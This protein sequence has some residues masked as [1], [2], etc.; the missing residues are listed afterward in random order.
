[1]AEFDQ[2]TNININNMICKRI[3]QEKSRFNLV[4]CELH[5]TPIHGK[6][7]TSY[8]NIES[9]YL[10]IEMFSGLSGISLYE[11]ENYR[12]YDTDNEDNDSVSEN[13]INENIVSHIS[14]VQELY[15]EEYMLMTEQIVPHRTIRN[16]YNI[17]TRPNYIKPEIGECFEL[18]TGEQIIIIKTIWIKL[19]QKKW[20]N[21]FATKKKIIKYRACPS[22]ITTRQITGKWPDHCNYM[23]G[24]KGMLSNIQ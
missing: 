2:L 5:Y 6:T 14:H 15:K 3:G 18:P 12:E 21:V 24:L 22:S 19:I 11:F 23:P 9:H 16:Y 1:M 7:R 20:K 8:K 13:S 10:L 4:L 17:V